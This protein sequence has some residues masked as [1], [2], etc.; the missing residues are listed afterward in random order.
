MSKTPR[1]T[2]DQIRREIT[3]RIIEAIKRGTAPWRQPWLDAP[4]A[5]PPRN[6]LSGRRYSGINPLIL[7]ITN[8]L[9]GYKSQNWGTSSSWTKALGVHVKKGEQATY[10]TLFRQI[11]KKDEATG[12]VDVGPDNK[13]RTIPIMR[14]YPVFNAEQLQAP[15]VK[16]LL[17]I[18]F[19]FGIVRTLLGDFTKGKRTTATTK[20]EL[21]Q[22]A[23]KYVPAKMR[24][25][26]SATREQ[27]AQAIH[28]GINAKLQSYMVG[29]VVANNEPD[30]EPAEKW[31]KA[32][33]ATIKHS[34]SKAFYRPKPGDY[35]QLPSKRSFV[36]M[37]DYYQTAAHEL[38][39]WSDTEGRVGKKKL[40]EAVNA[41]AFGELVAEIGACFTLSVLGVPKSEKMLPKSESYL[42]HWLEQMGNNPKYIFDAASQASKCSD[43]LLKFVGKENP[44]YEEEGEDD[45]EVQERAVA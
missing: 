20:E 39:H 12:A 23:D 13:P 22:I 9:H 10:V 14:I 29:E 8:E 25:A 19:P 3:D 44:A 38:V 6:F 16:T 31:M 5:G 24:P 40:D 2:P 36:S 1:K 17:G 42:A 28:D 32:T 21:L 4:N 35:I 30:F 15:E 41:Y 43:Y 11:P 34:G 27:I 26:K 33:G 37:T 18:P 45:G 7:W